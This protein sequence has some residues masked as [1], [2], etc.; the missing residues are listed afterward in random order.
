MLTFFL[1]DPLLKDFY[2]YRKKFMSVFSLEEDLLIVNFDYQIFNF[3][4][5]Y[6]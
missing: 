1:L 6:F 4:L 3:S 5:L 2:L